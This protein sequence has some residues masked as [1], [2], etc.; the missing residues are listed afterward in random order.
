MRQGVAGG[1]EA[2]ELD[3]APD[4]DEVA[5]LE[6]RSTPPMRRAAP[7]CASTCAPVAAIEPGVAAGVVAVLVRVED[8]RD[9][10]AAAPRGI[11]A[12]PPLERIDRER[13][14]GLRAGD[15]IV[16]IA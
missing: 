11:K 5:A 2:L 12:Q 6:A 14:A 10:P 1:V 16:K 7:A 13:L 15:Q 3:R 8:L 9:L 4:A